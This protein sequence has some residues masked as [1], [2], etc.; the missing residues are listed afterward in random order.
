MSVQVRPLT[1][2]R[3][4][5]RF[6]RL[7]WAIYA[8]DRQWVPPL[9]A[10]VRALM[11]RDRHPFHAHADVEFFLA[12]RDGAPV[13]RIA[14]VVNHAYNRFH[15]E[16][17]GFFG[18]FE[19]VDDPAVA[20]ALLRA[21]EGWLGERGM[22][23]CLG[24]MNLST[25][26]ELYSPGVLI[27]GAEHPPVIMMGHAPP[28]YP[29]LLEGAGYAKAKD[30]FAY[31][32]EGEEPPER[33]ARG[34]QRMLRRKHVELRRLE[35]ARFDE[36]LA[37][38]KAI[39]NT[40]WE[41][42]WGFV[43]MTDAEIDHMAKSLKPLVDERLCA[44]AEVDGKAVA[45]I[46]MLPDYNQVLRHMNGRMLPFG[47]LKFLWYKRRITRVR[48]LTLGVVPE[49]RG[50]GLDSFLIAH[51]YRTSREMGMPR[52]ECSWILEDNGPMNHALERLGHV[53]KR[54]RIYERPLGG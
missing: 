16:R 48:V 34:I 20:S 19:S 29:A 25:N 40:A 23:R 28:Y 47:W 10:D 52:G 2:R 33:M 43:P 1:G 27:E 45:F 18:L 51:V 35:L 8:D 38:V 24:P 37:T 49:Y 46:L 11:D 3:E 54:Y 36:E 31:W 50:L 15:E 39:Y 6:I 13:G 4:R 21:A 42:N 26:E 12:W 7:P 53:Y 17:T 32:I 9:R 30:L 22:A 44:F 5:E 14:A 41:R